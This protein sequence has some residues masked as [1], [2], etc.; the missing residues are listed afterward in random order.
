MSQVSGTTY[1]FRLEPIARGTLHTYRFGVDGRWAPGGDL[2]GYTSTS[3][4][5]PHVRPGTLSERHTISSRAYPGAETDYWIYANHGID[6]DRGAPLMVWHDGAGNLE[7]ADLYGLRMQIVTDNLVH[8]G[9]IPP[10]VHVLVSPSP[11]GEEV[12]DRPEGK[13]SYYMR[14]VQY[15]TVSDRYGRYLVDE[16]LPDVERTVK[17]RQDAYSRGT[18]GGSS[19]GICAFKLGWFQPDRF[20]RV[21]SIV[22]SFTGL[23]WDP[24]QGSSGGFMFPHLVRREPRRNIRVWM[25]DGANDWEISPEGFRDFFVAGSWPLNNIQ[26]ANALKMSGYDFHFRFGEGHHGGGQGALDLPESLAWLWRDYDPERTSQ[27]FEQEAAERAKPVFR[28]RI[29]NRDAS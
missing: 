15:D 23:Q 5:L 4:E 10:M 18:A 17:L 6:E 16:V 3:Y 27:V 21:H 12:R 24:E 11:D 9:R 19:G 22:G 13:R 8:L 25:S 26:L 14:S 7:P 2:A 28:V 29:T 1:W 20:S